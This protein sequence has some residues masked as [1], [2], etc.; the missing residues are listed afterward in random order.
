MSSEG[1]LDHKG[2]IFKMLQNLRL[3]CAETLLNI[4]GQLDKL[5]EALFENLA[6]AKLD[7]ELVE[8]PKHGLLVAYVE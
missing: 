7:H 4:G 2:I 3:L 6:V 8:A 5:G 1:A